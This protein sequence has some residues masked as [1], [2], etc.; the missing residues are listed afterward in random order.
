MRLLHDI[1]DLLLA[2]ACIGCDVPGPPL[3]EACAAELMP[4]P[5]R[6]PDLPPSLPPTVAAHRYAGRAQTAVL[7]HKE[8]GVRAL[9]PALGLSL[10]SAVRSPAMP[11]RVQA[12]VPVPSHAASIRARGRDTVLEIARA[13]GARMGVPV[14]PLLA[15][16]AGARQKSRTA[17]QRRAQVAGVRVRRRVDEAVALVLVDDVVATGSTADACVQ[18]LTEAGMTVTGVACVA[19]S[20]LRGR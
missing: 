11:P 20:V 4:T 14:L 5:F 12:L 19:A 13:A 7:A 3:C 10:A 6:V 17:A 18:A 1:A 2:R 8:S 16:T 9:S 15:R